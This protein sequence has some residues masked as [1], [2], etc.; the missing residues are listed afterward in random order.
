M[1][2]LLRRGG[3]QKNGEAVL[4][5]KQDYT[6]I[7][8]RNTYENAVFEANPLVRFLIPSQCELIGGA[9]GDVFPTHR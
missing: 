4:L 8:A 9:G 1:R 6:R 7:Q 3:R 2:Q 5:P